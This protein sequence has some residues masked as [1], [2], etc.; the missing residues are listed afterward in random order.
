MKTSVHPYR[1]VPAGSNAPGVVL[2]LWVILMC[3]VV[4]G[5][6]LPAGSPVMVGL[7]RLRINDKVMHFAAYL[8]LSLLPVIGFRDRRKGIVAGLSMFALGVLLEGGQHFSPG[9]AVELGDAIADG[10]G[11]GCG[12][13]LAPPIR[14]RLAML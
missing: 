13:L 8:V 11:V 6:L 7:G 10:V 4:V 2:L 9:R 12:V 5:S 14:S 1:L 3:A